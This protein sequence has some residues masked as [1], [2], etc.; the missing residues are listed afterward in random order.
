MFFKNAV[1]AIL[2]T[3]FIGTVSTAQSGD[4]AYPM[5][6]LVCEPNLLTLV[7]LTSHLVRTGW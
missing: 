6:L 2:A 5:Y 3:A 4:G 7:S 1:A